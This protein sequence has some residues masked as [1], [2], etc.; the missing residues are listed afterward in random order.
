MIFLTNNLTSLRSKLLFTV[1]TVCSSFQLYAQAGSFMELSGQ[2]AD[3]NAHLAQT[4]SDSSSSVAT[5]LEPGVCQSSQCRS[6]RQNLIDVSKL[7]YPDQCTAKNNYLNVML[8]QSPQ[9]IKDLSL[10]QPTQSI[11]KPACTNAAMNQKLLSNA[12]YA[13][14]CY[15]A[16]SNVGRPCVNPTY[17]QL[18]HNSFDLVAKCLK[19]FLEEDNYE[20]TIE[21][22][23]GKF[24][25]ES[26]FHINAVSHSGFAGIGQIGREAITDVNDKSKKG[27][28]ES[29]K[30]Y[31]NSHSEPSCQK[32]TQVLKK[33][34]SEKPNFSATCERTSAD[35]NSP[36]SNLLYSFSYRKIQRSYLDNYLSNKT[37]L[38]R[39]GIKSKEEADSSPSFK[40]LISKLNTWSYNPGVGG[41]IYS[42]RSAVLAQP[43]GYFKSK[44]SVDILL[45]SI[46]TRMSGSVSYKDCDSQREINRKENACYLYRVTEKQKDLRQVA[47]VEK[48]VNI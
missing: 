23:L 22:M 37:L 35:N 30:S 6:T 9:I 46:F 45:K 19:G 25:I 32:L 41:L 42:V 7:A 4:S 43:P 15:N 12:R 11:V 13:S 36:L 39:F 33:P 48:C 28:L 8:I 3:Y 38:E 14:K 10:A 40:Y 5:S 44:E 1:L 29:L 31:L 20:A 16:P 47:G 2:Y 26:N 27:N 18:M 21:E 24:S 17:H 34:L